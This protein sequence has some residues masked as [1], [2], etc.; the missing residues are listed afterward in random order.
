VRPARRRLS[1]VPRT[2]A[3][4]AVAVIGVSVLLIALTRARP[5]YDA[6]GW[7]VWG[8]QTLHGN[9]NTDGAP[10]WKPLTFLFTLPYSLL[11]RHLA[12]SLWVITAWAGGLAGAVFAA[13]IAYKLTPA[14]PEHR[15]A[16]IA[17]A[18]IAGG[19]LL[20]IG[21]LAHLLLIANSDPF[22]TTLCLAAIDSHLSRRYRLAF[23]V[24]VLVGLARPEGWVF[25]G[26]YAVWAWRA[27]P[28]MRAMA[29]F[30]ILLMLAL[31]V[32]VPA[33]TS[34]SVLHPGDLALGSP[35]QIHGSK[36]T[37]VIRRWR[38]L[39]GLPIQIAALLGVTW[40]A[41]RRD[42]TWLVL[43]AAA[44]L[45]VAIE[46]AFALHGFSAVAR[47]LLEPAAVV[48]VLGAAAIGRLLNTLREL[49]RIRLA[50]PG[51]LVVFVLGLIP[52]LH[53]DE[54]V[55]RR[56]VSD[57][58]ANAALVSRLDD[59]IR[60]VG[61]AKTIRRC[62][63]PVGPVGN[64]SLL[65]WALDMNVGNVG[66]KPGPAIRS[67]RPVVVFKPHGHG[68]SVR[69]WHPRPGDRARCVRLR[70]QTSFT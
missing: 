58:R 52:Y 67:G 40:A 7:L 4:I 20:V 23:V 57:Q 37:G 68:W 45:W 48:V 55:S 61:G 35:R 43:A 38:G 44:V 60:D 31:W 46:F 11:G 27:M 54:R 30:G 33:L 1:E 2:W 66:Y 32:G 62:G 47:Y 26:I 15:G 29:A 70:R 36:L 19:G 49:P 16:P 65:A 34:H 5:G 13:R 21:D 28:A 56:Q 63:Q 18:A 41:A 39:L 9:L 51:L 25:A 10:S 59:L 24:L 12:A 42:W 14:R 53:E 69:A 6:F 50:G 3:I 17:A 64:Q 8:R 22:T